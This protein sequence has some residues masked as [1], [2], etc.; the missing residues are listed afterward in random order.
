MSA[1]EPLTGGFVNPVVRAGSTVR[2]RPGPRSPFVHQL[3][4]HLTAAGWSASPRF[5]G[6]DERGREVLDFVE[7]EAAVGHGLRAR[8]ADGPA[9]IGVTRLV[10]ELHDLTAGSALAGEAEVVCHHDLDP[11]NTIYRLVVGETVPVA[12]IDWDL[13]GPGR[14]IEDVARI[15]WQYL[16][17]GPQVSDLDDV[18]RRLR[19]ICETYGLADRRDLLPTV[20][21]WQ[22]RCWR[23][24]DAAADAGDPAMLEL[25]RRRVVDQVLAAYDWTRAH[26]AEL[27]RRLDSPLAVDG[28]STNTP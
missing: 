17:L 8:V 3:L 28:S 22:E 10:R 9:L 18:G 12:F 6:F 24:I 1:E 20:V 13:A 2:R 7:G 14:R 4:E 27:T 19:L 5:L 15:A 25:R 26:E 23:G 11:R 16:P 21:W